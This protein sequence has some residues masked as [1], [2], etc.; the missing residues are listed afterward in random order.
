MSIS[1][2]R[3]THLGS[4]GASTC[5][6]MPSSGRCVA[7]FSGRATPPPPAG[8]KYMVMS[9]AF[10]APTLV[11]QRPG[12]AADHR[13]KRLPPPGEALHV[14]ADS[15]FLEAQHAEHLLDHRRREVP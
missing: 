15:R 8:G 9:S 13:E 3:A 12:P 7:S 10:T 2:S 11:R 5:V 1:S 4:S 6:S 14:V